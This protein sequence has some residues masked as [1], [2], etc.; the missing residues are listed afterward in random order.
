MRIFM[1]SE[2]LIK[3]ACKSENIHMDAKYKLIHLGYPIIVGVTDLNG[4]ST[5]GRVEISKNE[6]T[7][8]YFWV[9]K[10]TG[11]V[12]GLHGLTFNPRYFVANS[13]PQ[14]SRAVKIFRPGCK[15]I[16]FWA[17]V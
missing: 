13:A 10:K 11:K 14:I 6:N 17:H 12:A 1:T 3:I 15:R 4:T 2:A 7:S 8:S 9:L 5:L 16:N